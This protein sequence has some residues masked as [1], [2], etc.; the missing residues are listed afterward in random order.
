ME[1]FV[2]TT[3]WEDHFQALREAISRTTGGEAGFPV[4]VH[5]LAQLRDLVRLFPFL[6]EVD[7]TRQ[8]FLS[9]QVGEVFSFY[10]RRSVPWDWEAMGPVLERNPTTPSMSGTDEDGLEWDA[11][12]PKPALTSRPSP[13]PPSPR[14]WVGSS[15]MGAGPLSSSVA[16]MDSPASPRRTHLLSPRVSPIAGTWWPWRR[17]RESS[18]V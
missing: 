10:L 9:P 1:P 6:M 3:T 17:R 13:S 14:G 8:D 11:R 7:E 12:G 16:L 2:K 5:L 18:R 4:A 15:R